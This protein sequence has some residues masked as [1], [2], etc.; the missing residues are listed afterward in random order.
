MKEFEINVI[1]KIMERKILNANIAICEY[2]AY[3]NL[4]CIDRKFTMEQTEHLCEEIKEAIQNQQN[5]NFLGGKN[6]MEYTLIDLNDYYK[7][8]VKARKQSV[9]SWISMLSFV[10]VDFSLFRFLSSFLDTHTYEE[11]LALEQAFLNKIGYLN[12]DCLT[13]DE[14]EYYFWEN[15]TNPDTFQGDRKLK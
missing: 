6:M 9:D 15:Y 14:I 7:E 4:P 5:L 1:A 11:N 12:A 8:I 13:N 10:D 2:I 3:Q